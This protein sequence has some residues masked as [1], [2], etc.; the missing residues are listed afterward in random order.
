MP[1]QGDFVVRQVRDAEYA[2]ARRLA[3]RL[4]TTSHAPDLVLGAFG[5]DGSLL[6]IGAVAW[7]AR[8]KPA[9]FPLHVEVLPHARRRGVGRALVDV[10]AQACREETDRLHGWEALQQD[11]DAW[12]FAC[13]AGFEAARRFLHFEADASAFHATITGLHDWMRAHWQIPANV[14]TCA[15]EDVAAEPVAR[16]VS[17]T[18]GSP[19]EGC[20]ANV[21]GT[22]IG[23]YDRRHSVVLVQD[24]A[25]RGALLGRVTDGVGDVDVQVMA[26]ELRGGWANVLMLEHVSRVGRSLGLVKFQF[27]CDE[28]VRDSV[29]V[30]RRLRAR[31]V[32]T[33]VE[34][35][36]AIDTLGR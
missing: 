21:R 3:P 33:T 12:W 31:L 2:G 4:F 10:A 36:A 23:A 1:A 14:T 16:L 19:Y 17:S 11:S 20:L 5:T 8:G 7:Q 9:G 34:V 24:G 13:A 30:A 35:T 32:R 18:F 25:V 6:G 29:N 22:G 15:L 27:R 26:P 28:R